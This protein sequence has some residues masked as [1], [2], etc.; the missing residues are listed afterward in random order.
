MYRRARPAVKASQIT[1]A[2]AVSTHN[3]RETL[4]L[5]EQSLNLGD[6]IYDTSADTLVFYSLSSDYCN[7]DERRGS[8]GTRGR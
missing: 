6:L 5:L 1:A 2:A 4:D 3:K 7:R 8:D